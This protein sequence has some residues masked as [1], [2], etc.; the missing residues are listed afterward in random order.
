VK[1]KFKKMFKSLFSTQVLPSRLDLALLM[2]RLSVGGLML[3]HGYPKLQMLLNNGGAEFPDPL[4]VGNNTSLVLVV[5]AEFLCSIL[6]ILGA[7]TR[8]A[9]LS[10][11]ICMAVAV[12]KFHA[13]DAFGDK[14]HGLLFLLPCIVLWLTGPGRYSVDDRLN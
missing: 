2:L 13:N 14:E 11:I 7:G 4:G 12:F 1:E 3:T 5:F 9:L 8:L 6:L 10:L